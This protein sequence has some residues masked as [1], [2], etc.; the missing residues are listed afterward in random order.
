MTYI[1][2]LTPSMLLKWRALQK[3]RT[4]CRPGE[5]IL[6]LNVIYTKSWSYISKD[7]Y[8]SRFSSGVGQI[9]HIYVCAACLS[10]LNYLNFNYHNTS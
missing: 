8:N 10:Y 5:A 6:F 9:K 3:C 4:S 2:Y 7:H 1:F